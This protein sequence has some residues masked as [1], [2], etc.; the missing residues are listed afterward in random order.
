MSKYEVAKDI[1][2]FLSIEYGDIEEVYNINYIEKGYVDSFGIIQLFLYIE[3]KYGISF[4]EKER[5]DRDI[6][7]LEG[8]VNKILNKLGRDNE[9]I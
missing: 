3:D 4:D 2:D 5:I 9:E 1:C 8:L 6:F 7:T